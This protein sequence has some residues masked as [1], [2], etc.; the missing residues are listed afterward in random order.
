MTDDREF[1]S[2]Q[3]AMQRQLRRNG[4]VGHILLAVAICCWPLLMI[5]L[6][7]IAKL[8]QSASD[9]AVLLRSVLL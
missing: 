6:I 3:R 1:A 9:A 2:V 7:W 4:A 8:I 5:V